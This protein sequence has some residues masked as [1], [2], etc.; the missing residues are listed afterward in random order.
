MTALPRHAEASP[1]IYRAMKRR[2][3]RPP[4]EAGADLTFAIIPIKGWNRLAGLFRTG[5]GRCRPASR[6]KQA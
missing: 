4:S 3:R 5:A 6:E 1:E 2:S